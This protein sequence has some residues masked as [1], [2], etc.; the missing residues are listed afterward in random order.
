[1]DE[2]LLILADRVTPR[3]RY[4]AKLIF[5][6]LLG[7]Q[8]VVTTNHSAFTAHLGPRLTYRKHLMPGIPG[9]IPAGFLER[10]DIVEV[11]TGYGYHRDEVVLFP[12]Q[13]HPELPFDVFSAA[14]FLVSR[15]EEYLPFIPDSH[16]RFPAMNSMAQRMGFLNRPLV[17]IWVDW[18]AEYVQ[19][20]NSGLTWNRPTYRFIS[21]VDIDNSFAYRGKGWFRVAGGLAQ[22][23]L[24]GKLNNAKQR[25][26]VLLH[27]QQ[28][29]YDTFL[30]QYQVQEEVGFETIYFLL[31]AQFGRFDRNLPMHSSLLRKSIKFIAD[32]TQVGIHPSYGSH[33][34]TKVLAREV[35]GLSEVLNRDI[36]LSRQH[37]LKFSMPHTFRHLMQLGISHDY[38]M[39]YPN[40]PGF[41]AGICHPFP[42]Y[43]VENETETPLRMHPLIFL[44]TTFNDHMSMSAQEAWPVMQELIDRVKQHGG[45][46]VTVWHNRTF[47]EAE[48][49]WE[50]WNQLYRTMTQYAARA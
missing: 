37:F 21:T 18:L 41:R 48:P 3:L 44:E 6:E 7:V 31:F 4:T 35:T 29:P 40:Q 14:F 50:G 32:F 43:D 5:G 2:P 34:S 12:V 25:L 27:Q 26:R 47:S 9:V 10:T 38:S 1:M 22:D 20:G 36:T 11:E 28:D 19:R 42:W 23:V 24:R 16:G 17:N 13:G 33:T 30:Y 49:A 39:G 15:Y 46:C 8:A 45:E